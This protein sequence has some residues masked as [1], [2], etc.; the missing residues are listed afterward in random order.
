M[1]SV[2]L[3]LAALALTLSSH[4]QNV[5]APSDS[6]LCNHGDQAAATTEAACARL[7]SG[8]V[9]PGAPASGLQSSSPNLTRPTTS[10]P[11]PVVAPAPS[12]TPNDVGE[13]PVNESSADMAS[14]Q[15]QDDD[16]ARVS[17]HGS[18][19]SFLGPLAIFAI[20]IGCFAGMAFY[21]LPTIIAL[22]RQKR[23]TIAILV[24]N[25]F[26]GWTFVGWVVALVWSLATE[27]G[28]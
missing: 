9:A 3:F 26:L 6:Y 7:R 22:V 27:P 28:R 23:N 16:Q 15:D 10:L 20:I 5:Q 11:A 14:G 2:F 13:S 24:L 12:P 8:A 17:L 4:A 19:L 21:F 1:M 18:W 25:L